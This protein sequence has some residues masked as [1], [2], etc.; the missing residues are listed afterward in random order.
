MKYHF[1]LVNAQYI[2]N[3]YM[4]TTIPGE[5]SLS[6]NS[7]TALRVRAAEGSIPH[8]IGGG[9]FV[10]GGYTSG[11]STLE[12]MHTCTAFLAVSRIHTFPSRNTQC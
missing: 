8:R 12:I 4:L 1:S 11:A 7:L 9:L 5:L 2:N 10:G 6:Y 3:Q